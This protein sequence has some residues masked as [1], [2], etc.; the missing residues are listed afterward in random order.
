MPILMHCSWARLRPGWFHGPVPDGIGDQPQRIPSRQEPSLQSSPL[1]SLITRG[2]MPLQ[3]MDSTVPV[4][5][6]PGSAGAESFQM[7]PLP[8][9]RAGPTAGP[10]MSAAGYSGVSGTGGEVGGAGPEATSSGAGT[11]FPRA[12]TSF[13]TMVP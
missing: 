11:F 10:A 12:I 5:P 13:G 9:T 1:R 4:P 6:W 8:S 3:A 2:S 7:P